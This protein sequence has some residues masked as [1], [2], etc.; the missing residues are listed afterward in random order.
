MKRVLLIFIL[1]SSLSAQDIGGIEIDLSCNLC[2]GGSD[3]TEDAGERFD[4]QTTG[5]ELTGTHQELVCSS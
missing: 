1:L 4:H 2:H 3:W 5:F